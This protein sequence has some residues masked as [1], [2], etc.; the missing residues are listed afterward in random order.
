[1]GNQNLIIIDNHLV[2]CARLPPSGHA[3]LL[4]V[5][6]V[7]TVIATLQDLQAIYL[8]ADGFVRTVNV[9]LKALDSISF[10]LAFL[11][12]TRLF[13]AA[14]ITSLLPRGIWTH[15]ALDVT[16]SSCGPRLGLRMRTAAWR[17]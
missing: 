3:T 7:K 14:W 4:S 9:P 17:R 10:P 6:M 16:N 8:L 12:L 5:D 15:V 1:M 11:G 13:A 2:C